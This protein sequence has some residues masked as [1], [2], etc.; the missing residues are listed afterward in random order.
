M[1]GV[2]PLFIM[3]IILFLG[4]GGIVTL[5]L[6]GILILKKKNNR[7]NSKKIKFFAIL[8]TVIIGIAT[9]ITVIGI[10]SIIGHTP[11]V[12]VS[13]I[14]FITSFVVLIVSSK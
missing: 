8:N 1:D 5:I 6:A 13:P 9:Y 12:Y 3:L 2:V 14:M 4:I 10:S 7:K 11:F